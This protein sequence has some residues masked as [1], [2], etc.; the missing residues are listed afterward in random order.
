MCVCVWHVGQQF[1]VGH[2]S[3]RL[4]HVLPAH[5]RRLGPVRLPADISAALR[6]LLIKAVVVAVLRFKVEHRETGRFT[7]QR[8]LR[9][10]RRRH[11]AAE[12]IGPGGPRPVHSLVTVS[13]SY[14]H[15]WPLHFWA[16]INITY[17]IT[18]VLYSNSDV[19]TTTGIGNGKV[20]CGS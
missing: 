18:A 7:L 14:L 17:Y 16:L 8:S 19:L 15:V 11:R 13:D 5:G 4:H 12:A 9:F 6:L 10:R 1:D 20:R 3:S 2:E